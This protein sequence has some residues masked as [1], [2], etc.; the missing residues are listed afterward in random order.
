MAVSGP[1]TG[2]WTGV[3]EE[4]QRDGLRRGGF[5]AGDG[6]WG[7]KRGIGRRRDIG[8]WTAAV[9]VVAGEGPRRRRCM[10]GGG[11]EWRMGWWGQ[12]SYWPII[13]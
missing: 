4:R 7:E 10:G 5:L 3:G 1:G 12:Y 8:W 13:I 11:G 9:A 2:G 6:G